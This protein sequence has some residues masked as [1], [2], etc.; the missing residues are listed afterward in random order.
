VVHVTLIFFVCAR[1]EGVVLAAGFVAATAI[2]IRLTSRL[3]PATSR[4]GS[5]TNELMRHLLFVLLLTDQFQISPGIYLILISILHTVSMLAPFQMRFLIR[6]MAKSAKAVAL[7]NMVL[8]TAS[9]VPVLT[10]YIAAAFFTTYLYSF[11]EGAY[12]W[13]LRDSVPAS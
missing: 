5:P 13:T 6:G 8:I 3:D 1:Y 11:A 4:G 7:V 10:P 2:I 12:R 9:L